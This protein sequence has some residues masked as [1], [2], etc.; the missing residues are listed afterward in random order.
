LNS[1]PLLN[2]SS[3]DLNLV[4]QTW[5]AVRRPAKVFAQTLTVYWDR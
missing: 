2:S 1:I 4:L 5:S 3:K